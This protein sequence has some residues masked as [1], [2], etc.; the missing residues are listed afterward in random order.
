MNNEHGTSAI[1]L[2]DFNNIEGHR[3][4]GFLNMQE[5]K[6]QLRRKKAK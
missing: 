2:H 5:K 3:L 6:I 1:S 4:S